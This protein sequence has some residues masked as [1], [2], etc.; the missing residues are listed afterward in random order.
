MRG[1]IEEC[2][3]MGRAELEEEE[4]LLVSDR[5]G[6]ARIRIC[7][8]ELAR[9]AVAEVSPIPP[10]TSFSFD[11]LRKSATS[12]VQWFALLRFAKGETIEDGKEEIKKEGET[13]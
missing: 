1:R 7:Q 12:R 8:D 5:R 6:E 13:I 9:K 11:T 4:Q 10:P 3:R 2:D